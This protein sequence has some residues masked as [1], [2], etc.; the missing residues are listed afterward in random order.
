MVKIILYLSIYICTILYDEFS[1]R[2][3]LINRLL[4]SPVYHW[5]QELRSRR[6][7]L[8]YTSF[9]LSRGSIEY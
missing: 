2:E 1:S 8:Y 4:L 7:K 6:L 3:R 5:S 9:P